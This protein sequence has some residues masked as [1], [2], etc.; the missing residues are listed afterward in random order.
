LSLKPLPLE[1]QL[2]EERWRRR[3]APDDC[4]QC[5]FDE[6]G[7]QIHLLF[8]SAWAL[9]GGNVLCVLLGD[10]AAQV[11]FEPILFCLAI[12]LAIGGFLADCRLCFWEFK[13]HKE[14][15]PAAP[16]TGTAEGIAVSPGRKAPGEAQPK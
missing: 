7:G 13:L 15:E 3:A 16:A 6:W 12:L 4:F 11:R 10:A 14:R 1:S 5:E 9:L 8:C 2:D